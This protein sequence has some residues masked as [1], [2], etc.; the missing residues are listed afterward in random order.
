MKIVLPFFMG[1]SF[2]NTDTFLI[3]ESFC[4]PILAYILVQ[5]PA[6]Y[7]LERKRDPI[8]D[9]GIDPD[10]RCRILVIISTVIF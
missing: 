8:P 9:P 2:V 5:V 6:S 7:P 4:S 1:I 10:D 3:L